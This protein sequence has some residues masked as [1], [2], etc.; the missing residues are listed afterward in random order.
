VVAYLKSLLAKD[1]DF[2]WLAKER[3]ARHALAEKESDGQRRLMSLDRRYHGFRAYTANGQVLGIFRM[4]EGSD[5]VIEGR[6]GVMPVNLRLAKAWA[7]G[8]IIL[9]PPVGQGPGGSN[10]ECL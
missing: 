9:K 8:K 5:P 4:E 1:I 7:Q 6:A 10:L 2:S 3:E